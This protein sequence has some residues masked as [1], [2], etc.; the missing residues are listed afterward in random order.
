MTNTGVLLTTLNGNK[1]VIDTIKDIFLY[2]D[3]LYIFSKDG[4]AKVYDLALN[5]L[6][7]EKFRFCA[8]FKCYPKRR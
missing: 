5:K 6:N 1:R 8:V 2:A 3:R 7:E 4:T